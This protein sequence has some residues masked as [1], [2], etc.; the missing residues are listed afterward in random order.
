[1][2]RAAKLNNLHERETTICGHTFLWAEGV[3]DAD[4]CRRMCDQY[5]DKVL[6]RRVHRNSFSDGI[7]KLEGQWEKFIA[8]QSDYVKKRCDSLLTYLLNSVYKN[9]S[10]ETF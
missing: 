7:K 5:G 4:V 2:K 1:M 6:S 10:A 8:K 3:P 9:T